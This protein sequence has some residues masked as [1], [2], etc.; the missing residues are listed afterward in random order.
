M[1]SFLMLLKLLL[2]NNGKR[3]GLHFWGD[4]MYVSPPP[5][6]HCHVVLTHKCLRPHSEIV[7]WSDNTFDNNS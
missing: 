3:G 7:V 1:K 2:R 5:S 4:T 6:E